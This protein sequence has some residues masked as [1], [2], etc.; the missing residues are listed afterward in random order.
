MEIV[1]V[2]DVDSANKTGEGEV[3]RKDQDRDHLFH[4]EFSMSRHDYEEMYKKC[5]EQALQKRMKNSCDRVS[6]TDSCGEITAEHLD[7]LDEKTHKDVVQ[8]ADQLAQEKIKDRLDVKILDSLVRLVDLLT[9]T[10]A[11]VEKRMSTKLFDRNS[12]RSG[13][14]GKVLHI[15]GHILASVV[16]LGVVAV[17]TGP[18]FSLRECLRKW[19]CVD[20]DD[21]DVDSSDITSTQ[22]NMK[23]ESVKSE[24]DAVNLVAETLADLASA[25]QTRSACLKCLASFFLIQPTK[26]GQQQKL[27]TE[28]SI[29]FGRVMKLRLCFSK[30]SKPLQ[31]VTVVQ[32][33]AK[34]LA[35]GKMEDGQD[36]GLRKC[37]SSIVT[38]VQRREKIAEEKRLNPSLSDVMDRVQNR[39][40]R[41]KCEYCLEQSKYVECIALFCEK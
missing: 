33:F 13:D 35:A 5:M 2:P 25:S 15:L 36:L 24:D 6:D 23:T 12:C 16:V 10:L 9:D 31:L 28:K 37:V 17:S 21:K 39:T 40:V 30:V 26:E 3:C 34:L 14:M 7:K 41:W 4:N 18:C 19:I 38:E 22:S 1:H 11:L 32:D 20:E 8:A 27:S 29:K